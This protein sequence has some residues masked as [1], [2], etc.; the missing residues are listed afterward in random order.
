M[1]RDLSIAVISFWLPGLLS[2]LMIAARA[3]TISD[4]YEMRP[5]H[6][7]DSS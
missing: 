5:G 2:E 4:L 1:I 6:L 7:L 3:I